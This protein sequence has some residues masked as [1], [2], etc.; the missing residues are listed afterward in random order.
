MS[1]GA[2]QNE[3]ILKRFNVTDVF[4]PCRT[5]VSFSLALR[6][7][8]IIRI[9]GDNVRSLRGFA[10]TVNMWVFEETIGGQKLTD[11]I[12]A[13]HENVKYLPDNELHDN[14]VSVVSV[15]SAAVSMDA[16]LLLLVAPH[17]FIH[18]LCEEMSAVNVTS[19]YTNCDGSKGDFGWT[20]RHMTP[21]YP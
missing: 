4:P 17:R 8:A 2:V 3:L 19:K 6:G 20:A 7:S 1:E 15:T 11:I 5:N 12:N 13:E 10:P 9:V 16:D 21:S 14:V 18:K